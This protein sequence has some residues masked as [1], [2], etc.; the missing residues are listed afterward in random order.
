MKISLRVKF[1]LIVMLSF[2]MYAVLLFLGSRLFYKDTVKQDLEAYYEFQVG[3]SQNIS[4]EISRLYPDYGRIKDFVNSAAKKDHLKITLFN[5]E[6]QDILYWDYLP[7]NSVNTLYK[8]FVVANGKVVYLTEIEYPSAIKNLV[9][10]F[11]KENTPNLPLIAGFIIFFSLA[12]YLH[13]SYVKPLIFLQHHL[14][15]IDLGK[16]NVDIDLKRK[17]E[18]GD[19]YRNFSAMTK[20]LDASYTHQLQMISSI[21]HDLKTPLTS[22]MGYVERLLSANINTEDKKR[23]YYK[24]IYNKAN[25][26]EQLIEDFSD[27]SKN[28]LECS[29]LQKENVNIRNFFSSLC[30]EYQEELSSYGVE[31][32]CQSIIPE[33]AVMA[34]D[35]KKIRRIIANLVANSLK[36][37][38]PP[39]IIKMLC[40]AENHKVVFIIEDNGEGVPE[41]ELNFLFEAFYRVD[42]SRSRDKGGSGLG[43]AICRSIVESHNGC[44]KAYNISS[45]GGF[46]VEFRL[47][48]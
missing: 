22:I 11:F 21:S 35:V 25:D 4:D 16:S 46:G 31:L 32:R 7:K 33:D 8:N 18:I 1:P 19:L 45:H 37:V 44:I 14:A 24:I 29:K 26:I 38:D 42:K 20:R 2:L 10:I 41:E 28:E 17:D 12:V 34:I 39:I 48:V 9:E 27:Y 43:L 15:K 30:G 40:L 3:I 23:E 13:Y 47:P 5:M 36:Y 6:G